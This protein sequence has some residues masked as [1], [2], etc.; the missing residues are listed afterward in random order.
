MKQTAI[1]FLIQELKKE[2]Y[3][4]TFCT[5]EC[6]AEEEKKMRLIIQQALQM[7]KEQIMDAFNEGENNSVDYFNTENRI[8][9]SEQYYN[10][11]YGGNK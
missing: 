4:G 8:K 11:T 2:E 10:E 3:L 9:E 1:E 6:F 5:A 7:E